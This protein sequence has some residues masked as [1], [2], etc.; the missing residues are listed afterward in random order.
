MGTTGAGYDVVAEGTE[1]AKFKIE[2][3]EKGEISRYLRPGEG[4]VRLLDRKLVTDT[5]AQ[6]SVVRS[7]AA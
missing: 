2:R 1:G 5:R 7:L 4:W 6:S 3:N